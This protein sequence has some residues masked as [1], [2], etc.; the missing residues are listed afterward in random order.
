L[1]IIYTNK[2]DEILVDDEDYEELS[3][4]KWHLMRGHAYRSIKRPDGVWTQLAMHRQIMGLSIGHEVFVDHRNLNRQ[5]N[6]RANLRIC[7]R[8]QNHYNRPAQS[9]SKSGIKG[10]RRQAGRNKWEAKIRIDG[11]QKVLG[12]F[13]TA[14][15]A[16]A[17]YKKAAIEIHGE[18]AN[19]GDRR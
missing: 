1:K 8:T 19:F 10:V 6:Q 11:R 4:F 14:E 5:D 2:G 12:Y 3:K 16:R 7:T 13:D 9:T 15:D 18:F 17:A